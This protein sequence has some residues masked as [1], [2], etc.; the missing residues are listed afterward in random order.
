MM[1]LLGYSQTEFLGRK[2]WEIGPFK[3]EAAS[4]LTFAELQRED[5]IRYEG[6]PLETKEG[7]RVEVEFISNA[8]L[9]AEKKLIQCN[10]RD[11]TSRKEIEEQLLWKT[12]LFEA[13]VHSALDGILIVDRDGQKVLQ[14]QQMADL[15]KIP[16]QFAD[17][18]DDRR[19][20]E[21]VT[22]Q[23]KNP[24]Q[25]AEKIAYLQ[26]HPDEISHDEI[27][28]LAVRSLTDTPRQSEARTARITAGFGPFAIS[29]NGKKRR[30]RLRNK[31]RF[32]TRPGMPSWCATL[33]EKFCF[34][35][36]EPNGCMAGYG[37]K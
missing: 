18:V 22:G 24:E 21:W 33:M 20:L 15:W 36:R 35:T 7:K 27:E 19:Q 1:D 26:S 14:N 34:G 11:I 29:R 2:L 37:K 17:D 3:G 9:V 12:A 28:L 4:K 25:F 8:Y 13:Q 10:I 30:L 16:P 23:V 6:L 31:Q 32:S 5:R